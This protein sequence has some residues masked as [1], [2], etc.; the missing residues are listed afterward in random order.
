VAQKDRFK[1]RA[2]LEVLIK[3]R[4]K[5]LANICAAYRGLEELSFEVDEDLMN[6]NQNVHCLKSSSLRWDGVQLEDNIQRRQRMMRS[7]FSSRLN[8]DLATPKSRHKSLASLSLY[9]FARPVS[10]PNHNIITT[11]RV[12]PGL[13]TLSYL[14]ITALASSYA[15]KDLQQLLSA[16]SIR[17]PHANN[18]VNKSKWHTKKTKGT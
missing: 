3:D 4:R 14:T 9:R 11:M 15:H 16:E 17:V 8:V 12:R 1:A 5:M 10:L 7:N 13:L 2:R 18:D 6:S